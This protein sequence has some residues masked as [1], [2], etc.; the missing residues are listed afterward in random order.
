MNPFRKARRGAGQA[1]AFDQNQFQELE[2]RILLST[3]FGAEL[4]DLNDLENIDNVI[5]RFQTNVEG[6]DGF[7]H[8]DL[9]LFV[10]DDGDPVGT[11][12]NFL[13]YIRDGQ[14]DGVFFQRLQALSA[15][16]TSPP[17]VLQGGRNRLDDETGEVTINQAR[18]AIDDEVGRENDER[19]VAMA[20]TSS[21]NSATT[22][23]YFN[24]TDNEDVL[25][26]DVQSNGGFAV[27]GR[28]LDDRSWDVV[29][30][31]AELEI[32]DLRGLLSDPVFGGGAFRSTPVTEAF[33]PDTDQVTDDMLVT[34]LDAEIIKPEGVRAFF[35]QSVY[36]SEGYK[37][38]RSDEVL[39]VTNTN[40]EEAGVQVVL[41]YATG[42]DR[43][44]VVDFGTFEPGE[45]RQLQLSG[46]G[47]IDG[48]IGFV[49][50]AV[51][52]QTA[53]EDVT[54]VPVTATLTRND[55]GD[56][57]DGVETFAGEGLFNPE[58][59]A[60]AD[61]LD[62]LTVWTFA[63]GERDDENIETFITWVNLTGEEGEIMI[64]FFFEDR[65]STQ[66]VNARTI[67]AYRRG[68][69]NVEGIG[70]S[71]LPQGA[72]SARVTSTVPIVASMTTFRLNISN[73]ADSGAAMAVG[74]PGQTGPRVAL[75]DV[76]RLD[77][78]SGQISVVNLG[79]VEAVVRFDFL[80]NSG[81]Q[82]TSIFNRVEAGR[83]EL[84][85]LNT[86]PG[87]SLVE[88]RGYSVLVSVQDGGPDIAAGFTSSSNNGGQGGSLLSTGARS[89]VFADA[90]F[91]DDSGFEE[92]ISIYNPTD[93][94][95]SF[96][97]IVSFD[98]GT[99]EVVTRTLAAG[100]RT[101][102]DISN[103]STSDLGDIQDKIDSG[104]SFENFAVTITSTDTTF[105]SLTRINTNGD[106]FTALGT[107]MAGLT[108]LD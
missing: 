91:N 3:L 62:D 25:S 4:P 78:G 51:E 23:F 74:A 43:D 22:Q 33:D 24:L 95:I 13:T 71:V 28:V 26:P 75:A 61:R 12:D 39:T 104:S 36:I 45:Q 47:G 70:E 67:G 79:S 7:G 85:D 48:V 2:S 101:S 77:G 68:G 88:D 9:E 64:E 105:T 16:P 69:V 6:P 84:F 60:E 15:D 99:R 29:T 38:N 53:S 108:P 40:D 86:I 58:A 37:N 11:V 82:R 17:D 5:V 35:D 21:P 92:A 27:F 66:T 18:D 56:E 50:Y 32:E 72:F 94:A 46:P 34:I 107:I 100:R 52:V 20:K 30:A 31:I 73:R 14:Y 59:I 19:T 83:R 57:I 65:D 1:D 97:Y 90:R 55:Y 102:I 103:D 49:P 80:D 63:D 98:D 76:R 10:S 81:N 89:H 96:N 54:S 42:E 44:L 41:R 106:R 93:A 87:T 8:F